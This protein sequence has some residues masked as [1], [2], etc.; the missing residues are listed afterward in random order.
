M[1]PVGRRGVSLIEVAIGTS[2][3]MAL[4]YVSSRPL[5]TLY[6]NTASLT[7]DIEHEELR[8]WIRSELDCPATIAAA[9]ASCS[10]PVAIKT[11]VPGAPDLI[12]NP[13]TS[14]GGE[15]AYTVRSGF[16]LKATCEPGISTSQ[17]KLN[18]QV[19]KRTT[20]EWTDL[21]RIPVLCASGGGAPPPPPPGGLTIDIKV[22][23]VDGPITVAPFTPVTV[24]WTSAGATS[25]TVK[26]LGR[27]ELNNAGVVSS[28]RWSTNYV[29]NCTGPT[30]S[31]F[32][33]AKVIVPTPGL[34]CNPLVGVPVALNPALTAVSG[35][36]FND[37]NMDGV[38]DAG[39]PPIRPAVP[40]WGA[41][42]LY[43]DL[44]Q[45]CSI[46]IL[47]PQ[48]EAG[49]T[50]GYS[51]D[52]TG[53]FSA[54]RAYVGGTYPI[55][56]SGSITWS[57]IPLN[58]VFLQFHL[59]VPGFL[60]TG[61]TRYT[62]DWTV[63]NG[64]LA[65]DA[66]VVPFDAYGD[67]PDS[68]GTLR[69]S[70]G[71]HDP[72]LNLLGPTITPHT[73]GQPDP[74]AETNS[75]DDGIVFPALPLQYGASNTVTVT[76]SPISLASVYVSGW[77]DFNRN[78][79]FDDPAERILDRVRINGNGATTNL[80]FTA[81]A[82]PAAPAGTYATYARFRALLGAGAIGPLGASVG[83]PAGE[84]EDYRVMIRSP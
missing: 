82:A 28:R 34:V 18:L 2:I 29:I 54:R 40:P 7:E 25:C 30:T 62:W 56:P 44:N 49:P 42:R 75:G 45:S 60:Y 68:Y 41:S 8:N 39:E 83:V 53:P 11:K 78:G 69:A 52:T 76:T 81:P 27:T 35:T 59:L 14:P 37:L 13:P 65:L 61:P 6:R 67:A 47:E 38:K 4:L 64:G 55:P 50:G 15:P 51:I 19:A 79:R 10:G 23:G 71:P 72:G 77:I 17:T 3:A 24:S 70:G 5:T 21:F 57:P 33:V 46:G 31:G 32:D 74:S 63:M 84:I 26:P 73:D 9:P 43:F 80:T 48:S 20:R 66:G 16:K 12:V 22:N 1:L 58:P 36:F